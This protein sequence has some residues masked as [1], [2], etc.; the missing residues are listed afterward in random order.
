MFFSFAIAGLLFLPGILLLVCFSKRIELGFLEKILFGSI[1]WNYLFV[2]AAVLLGLTSTLVTSYFTFFQIVSIT[3]IVISLILVARNKSS[4]TIIKPNLT[5]LPYFVVFSTVLIVCF[6]FMYFHSIFVEWDA[7]SYYIPSAKAILTSHGLTSQP[8]RLLS[9]YDVSPAIPM[10]YAFVLNLSSIDYLFDLPVVYFVLTLL[11]IFLM[12]KKFFSNRSAIIPVLIFMSLPTVLV[13]ISSRALYLDMPFV[14]FFFSSIYSAIR[15]TSAEKSEHRAMKFDY[16]MFFMGLTLMCLIRI[17]LG[18]FLIPV[19]IAVAMFAF[20]LKYWVIISAVAIGAVY[21]LREIRNMFLSPLSWLYYLERLAPVI[22]VSVLLFLVFKMVSVANN[23]SYK[24]ISK[25]FFVATLLLSIPFIAYLLRNI[26]VSGL[27]V[28]DIPVSNSS[29]FNSI[30][31]F[32]QISPS[33]NV[34]WTTLLR[35]DNLV[36]VW[37]LT[38]PYLAPIIISL[39]VLVYGLVK[40][41]TMQPFYVPVVFFFAG[42][43]ILWSILSCDPQP[44]RLYYFAPFVAIIAGHGL[45]TIREHFSSIG[46]ALRASTYVISVTIYALLKMQISTVNYVALFYSQLYQPESDIVFIIVCATLFLLIFFPYETLLTKLRKNLKITQTK[47][48]LTILVVVCLNIVLIA[49]TVGPMVV[50]TLEV[51]YQSRQQYTG[52]WYYYPDVTDYY[53]ENITDNYV[54]IGFFCNELITFSNRSVI[55][56]DNPIYGMPVYS[57][58]SHA[59]ETE[60]LHRFEE[61]NVG[62]LLIPRIGTPFYSIYERLANGTAF[63]KIFDTPQ[64]YPL[65]TF[66]YAT[67]YRFY[68]NYSLSPLTYSEVKPWNYDSSKTAR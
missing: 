6:L 35:W 41:H 42:L 29:I 54:T 34:S 3:I 39:S 64:V 17:E 48:R 46:F 21:Y 60:I 66:K 23:L 32:D 44:R 27:V 11:V 14:F 59:N 61:L 50:T 19:A 62:Y 13:T 56:L 26:T 36:S 38:S 8:Y 43:L 5:I 40:R 10:V 53:N 24:P 31:I 28:P 18:V 16:A 55:D 4:S 45:L 57:I 20:K 22:I 15:I 33:S 67:L 37:W 58:I 51:G 65:Q 12:S 9:F 63:G 68:A 1:L 30:T 47:C 7:I 2:S 49:S 25:K 52:G